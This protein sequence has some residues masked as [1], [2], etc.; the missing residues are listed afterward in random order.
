LCNI[1]LAKELNNRLQAAG[2]SGITA[3]S[4]NPGGVQTAIFRHSR[5]WFK[6]MIMIS[7]FFFKTAP[8]GA[9]PVVHLCVSEEVEG[10]GG[11]YWTDCKVDKPSKLAGDDEL[12]KNLWEKSAQLVKLAP[13]EY[14]LK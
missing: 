1:L 10:V 8:E 3:N 4:V 2:Y 11:K 7:Q 6:Y 14:H 12:A 9:Q 13:H 5:K